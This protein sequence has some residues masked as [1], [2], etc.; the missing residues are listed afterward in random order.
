VDWTDFPISIQE[1]EQERKK[2]SSTR[3]DKEGQR[4]MKIRRIYTPE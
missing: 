4:L 1:E 3:D 2:Q